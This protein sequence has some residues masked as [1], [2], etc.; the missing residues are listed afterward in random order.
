MEFT[1]DIG[2]RRPA[3]QQIEAQVAEAIADGIA[4]PR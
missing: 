1:I 2:G 3:Y 4:E